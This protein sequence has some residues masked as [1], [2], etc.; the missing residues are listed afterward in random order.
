MLATQVLDCYKQSLRVILM[1]ALMTG[2]QGFPLGTRIP[3]TNSRSRSH[4][5]YTLIKKWSTFFLGRET[6]W[7][8]KSNRQINLAE[9]ILRLW[10][11]CCWL[12][13]ARFTVKIRSKRK[14]LSR[15]R[16][17]GPSRRTPCEEAGHLMAS[18]KRRSL[19]VARGPVSPSR[20][21]PHLISVPWLCLL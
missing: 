14:S 19:A 11:R 5:C 18:G 2:L 6:L 1:R 3:S 10:C 17:H 12:F 21:H 9:E 8:T 4:V 7:K 20:A 13:S 15:G 16:I